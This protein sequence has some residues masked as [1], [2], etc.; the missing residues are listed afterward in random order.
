MGL[1]VRRSLIA[2]RLTLSD[3]VVHEHL[4]AAQAQ[5]R[6]RHPGAC[7]G[8]CQQARFEQAL[9]PASRTIPHF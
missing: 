2:N 8:T 1:E 9:K 5:A 6:L 7:R 4:L 3:P